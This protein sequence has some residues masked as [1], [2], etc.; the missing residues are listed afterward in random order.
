MTKDQDINSGDHTVTNMIGIDLGTTY[1]TV[2]Y[3]NELGQP[4]ILTNRDGERLTPSVVMFQ[5]EEPLVGKMAKH[6][7]AM[8]PD[9]VVQFV[10][11]FMGD[12]AWVHYTPTGEAFRPEE[13]SALI[14][15][16]L[17]EDAEYTLG[18][19]VTDAVIT[20][21]AYFDDARRKATRDAGQLA[22]L[23]VCRLLNEPTA[24]ALAYGLQQGE[25]DATL[26]VFDLGGGTF[27]VTVMRIVGGE[28]DVLATGGDR[29]LGGYDWDNL[30]MGWLNDQFISAG[31][32][33]LLDEGSLESELREKAES[34][35]RSLTSVAATKVMLGADGFIKPITL[36]REIFD[37]LTA[38]LLNRTRY[39]AE[40]VLEDASLGWSQIENIL[41]VGGSTR[42]PQVRKMVESLTGTTPERSINPDE[43][44]AQGAAVQAHLEARTDN[45]DSSLL[46]DLYR[47]GR[48]IEIKD[49][50][51]QSLGIIAVRGDEDLEYNSIIVSR[52]SKIPASGSSTYV[53]RYDNQEEIAIQVTEGDDEDADY[54]TILGA[55]AIPLPPYPKGAAIRVEL[56]YDVDQ[57][58]FVQVHDMT[59]GQLARSFQVDRVANLSDEELARSLARL[60]TITVA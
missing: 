38:D 13:V 33:D 34:A 54:V 17:K 26:L 55:C 25:N 59:T 42:M 4:E 10:K 29:N 27:D 12:P 44:V 1:S 58:V 2:A 21:P 28:F 39:L 14:L 48:R 57:T 16:R 15:K 6:S 37:D 32:A 50:T 8:A 56:A 45:A 22:G 19:T 46:P 52:N 36:T 20:V 30:T 11:R 5:D 18:T 41:L 60:K 35:K 40:E 53:T 24:A 9:D 49:V 47:Q 3:V 43:V 51:S 7:A 23:N 31:G